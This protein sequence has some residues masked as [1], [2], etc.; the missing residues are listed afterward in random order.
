[1]SRCSAHE[2]SRNQKLIET[3]EN[4]LAMAGIVNVASAWPY[5]G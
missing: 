4:V 3:I 2:H 5:F 1:M